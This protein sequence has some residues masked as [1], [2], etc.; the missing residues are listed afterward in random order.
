M[1]SPAP[2]PVPEWLRPGLMRSLEC[3]PDTLIRSIGRGFAGGFTKREAILRQWKQITNGF[4]EISLELCE[5]I[6]EHL[7]VYQVTRALSPPYLVISLRCLSG[8]A[9]SDLVCV[10]LWLDLRPDVHGLAQPEVL[11]DHGMPKDDAKK[12]WLKWLVHEFLEP[13]DLKASDAEGTAIKQSK[14]SHS[15]NQELA[16]TQKWLDDGKKRLSE[17]Q[18]QHQSEM[19]ALRAQHEAEIRSLTESRDAVLARSTELESQFIHEL[20]GEVDTVLGAQLRPWYARVVALEDQVDSSETVIGKLLGEINGALERQRRHDRHQSNLSRLRDD[21]NTLSEMQDRVQFSR[22]ESL[23]PLKEWPAL[24][25][26]LESSIRELQKQLNGIPSASPWSRQ[27]A[28]ELQSATSGP[29]LDAIL[30]RARQLAQSG[31]LENE[32]MQWLAQR[33]HERR[34]ILADPVIQSSPALPVRLQQVLDGQHPGIIVVDAYNWIGRA[35]GV[36]GVS[37]EPSSFALSLKQLKP[38]LKKW[39]S[40]APSAEICLFVDG[41]T[42]NSANWAPNLR[43]T[44]T[45]GVGQHRADIVIRGHLEFLHRQKNQHP[46]WVVTDDRDVRSF[47]SRWLAAVE[48]CEAFARR[49]SPKV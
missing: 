10:A 20:R 19:T 42:E 30:G 16:R 47:A 23:H 33:G 40:R 15:K 46:V 18:S 34:S 12:V 49:L 29:A 5:S 44:W 31:L 13:F 32:A 2:T 26:R 48:S 38:L 28:A 35:G 1:S 9:G 27:L 14:D 4:P 37:T 8:I 22:S 24:A 39:A 45:G 17:A 43:L 25:Q 7:P 3:L 41:P 11:F 6:R 36:L 21:L